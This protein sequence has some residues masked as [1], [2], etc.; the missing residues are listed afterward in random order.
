MID[1][2]CEISKTK[3][4][5]PNGVDLNGCSLEYRYIDVRDEDVEGII[6]SMACNQ[7]N[8]V[9]LLC[10]YSM[11]SVVRTIQ[12]HCYHLV[13]LYNVLLDM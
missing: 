10:Q 7:N 1:K 13:F 9:H 11:A 5:N 2:L 8:C 12:N 3:L 6:E 4:Q